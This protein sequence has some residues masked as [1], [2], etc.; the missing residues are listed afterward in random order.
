MTPKSVCYG[1]CQGAFQVAPE[2]P[3]LPGHFAGRP[4]VPGVVLL[5]EALA[6]VL[7][8]APGLCVT[9]LPSV[10]FLR[11]V[12]PGERVEVEHDPAAPGRV[13]FKCR[14]AGEDAVRGT[15]LLAAA[16]GWT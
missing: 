6:L 12:R 9:G 11:P 16:E 1:V 5:D 8:G 14:V 13:A 15:A 2:H 3:S 10:R 7:A 4:V